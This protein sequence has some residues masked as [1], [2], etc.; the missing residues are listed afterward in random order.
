MTDQTIPVCLVTFVLGVIAGV[1][2]T[3]SFAV[4]CGSK[5]FDKKEKK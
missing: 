4:Y 2:A 5:I 1:Y 3:L